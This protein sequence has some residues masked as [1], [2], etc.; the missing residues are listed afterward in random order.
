MFLWYEYTNELT[1]TRYKLKKTTTGKK[2]ITPTRQK[3]T[4]IPAKGEASS[5]IPRRIKN[6]LINNHIPLLIKASQMT[7]LLK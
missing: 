2:K 1:R 5:V 7:P 3:I 6:Q 4:H